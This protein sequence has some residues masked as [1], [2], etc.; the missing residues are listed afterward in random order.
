MMVNSRLI[1]MQNEGD[2]KDE[3]DGTT[4]SSNAVGCFAH[5]GGGVEAGGPCV[6]LISNNSLQSRTQ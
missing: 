3:H 1:P 2:Y 5:G 6:D 4:D